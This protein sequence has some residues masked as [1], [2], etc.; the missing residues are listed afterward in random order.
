MGRGRVIAFG[1]DP[2]YRAFADGTEKLLRNAI[3]GADPS[4]A[5]A[6]V[7]RVASR[8][9]AIAATRRLTVAHEPLRLVVRAKGARNAKRVLARYHAG[10]TTM[11]AHKRVQF[12]IYNPGSR[13]GDEHPYA[14]ELGV[15]LRR[16]KVPVMMYRVP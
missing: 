10:Y 12:V 7:A 16:A 8:R 11:R 5:K 2:N 4:S 6:S 14:R 3:F 9:R 13:D 15:S 1:F